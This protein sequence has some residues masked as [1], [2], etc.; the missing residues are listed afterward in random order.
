MKSWYLPL[1]RCLGFVAGLYGYTRL[2]ETFGGFSTSALYQQWAELSLVLY[3]YCLLYAL[4]KPMAW[5]AVL[6]A[7]PIFLI[8]LVHDVFYLIYGKVFRLI[9][10]AEL[11]ELLQV[12]PLGYALLVALLLFV[13]LSLF[14]ININY[15]QPARLLIGLLPLAGLLL[16]VKGTPD[17][18]ATSFREITPGIVKYSDAK[19]VENN[20]RLAMLFY[21]EAQR[22]EILAKLQPYRH[23]HDY[24]Q[25]TTE[26]VAAIKPHLTGRNVHMIVLESFLD[27]RLFKDLR[28]SRSPVHPAFDK[29]FGSNLGLSRSPV[30]GGAT[31]QAEFE[32]LCGV[33]ALE[34]VSS[35]EF[36]A[37]TGAPANCLPQVLTQL[38]YRTVA[39]NAYKPNFFNALPAYKGVGFSERYFPQEFYSASKSYLHFGHPGDEEFL[40]DAQL[41]EQNLG[42][43]ESHIQNKPGQPLFNYVMTIY[44]HTPHLLDTNKRP[45]IIKL[46]TAYKD[47]QLQRAVNQFY[48]RTEAIAN[49]IKQLLVIDKHS[50]IVL[51]SDH[52]PPLRNG[53]NTYQ[54][55]RYLDNIDDAYYYNRIA[56]ID[57]GVVKHFSPMNHYE[58][59]QLILNNLS[60]GTYCQSNPCAFLNKAQ[61]L[62]RQDYLENYLTLMAHASE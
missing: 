60:E 58:L 42:F 44:G 2:I 30:F 6:A 23:R 25:R 1:L 48:Y 51:V 5:R 21:R 3:L 32:V 46:Q 38:G 20:G 37:F 9:D 22:T 34:L 33:P 17:V 57:N 62:T 47:D 52:V 59:P 55:L 19:S 11:P 18:Y 56:I 12:L 28:F 39:S 16:L 61:R 14:V 15:R 27:P 4:L 29:L 13:P 24:D 53:P 43:I 40:F 35:V 10:I 31:A 41:F 8:Y 54:A 7:L 49:Y 50:L 36:N 26:K 45:E